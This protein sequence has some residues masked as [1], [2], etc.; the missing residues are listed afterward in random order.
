MDP[1]G[2]RVGFRISGAAPGSVPILYLSLFAG[3]ADVIDHGMG[4]HGMGVVGLAQIRTLFES[5]PI[6]ALRF[7]DGLDGKMAILGF[8]GMGFGG[9]AGAV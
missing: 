5:F 1:S 4:S 6:S 7:C 8:I 9:G 3:P 2:R